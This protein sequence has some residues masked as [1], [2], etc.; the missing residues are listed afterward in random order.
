MFGKIYNNKTSTILLV[1]L[2]N[3]NV[4]GERNQENPLSNRALLGK[5]W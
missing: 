3:V 2:Q 5:W 4:C 1:I